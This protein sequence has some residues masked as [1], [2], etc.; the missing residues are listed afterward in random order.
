MSDKALWVLQHVRHDGGASVLGVYSTAERGR[1]AC[2]KRYP[3]TGDAPLNVW[4]DAISPGQ[5]WE[6]GGSRSYFVLTRRFLDE[7]N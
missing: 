3:I 2:D 6:R 4:T 7:A 5:R 1:A